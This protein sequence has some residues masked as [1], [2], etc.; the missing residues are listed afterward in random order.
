MDH[1]FRTKPSFQSIIDRQRAAQYRLSHDTSRTEPEKAHYRR[2]LDPVPL[3]DVEIPKLPLVRQR[4]GSGSRYIVMGEIAQ[5]PSKLLL[6]DADYGTVIVHLTAD[7]LE[8]IP[9]E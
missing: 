4:D 1:L 3:A 6:I 9:P 8:L 5:N 2:T 7:Q